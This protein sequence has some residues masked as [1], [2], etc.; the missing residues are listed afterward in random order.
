MFSKKNTKKLIKSKK[1]VKKSTGTL[2]L[3]TVSL[4]KKYIDKKIK[5]YAREHSTL[6]AKKS[7]WSDKTTHYVYH[8]IPRKIQTNMV[9]GDIQFTG[10]STFVSSS[11][12]IDSKNKAISDNLMSSQNFILV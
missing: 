11:L 7:E 2:K 8:F 12:Q 9:E 5:I 4:I 1:S 6:P 3:L 10:T